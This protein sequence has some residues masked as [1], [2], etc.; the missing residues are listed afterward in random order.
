MNIECPY[1]QAA[2]EL[3]R[4]ITHSIELQACSN[5]LN[6]YAVSVA[7]GNPEASMLP[8]VNDVRMGARPDSLAGQ[9]L[10]C[11]PA[12]L[13]SL[14]VLPAISQ[15]V[16]ELVDDPE[17]SMNDLAELIRED[18]VM[19]T[20]VLTVSN[21]ALFG[22]LSEITELGNACARLGMQTVSGIVQTIANENLYKTKDP[23]AQALMEKLWHHAVATAYLSHEI[24]LLMSLPNAG[25]YHLAGLVHD[26]G[27]IALV[28][29]IYGAKKGPIAELKDKPELLHEIISSYHPLVGLHIIQG[30]NLP[31]E[32][33]VAAF[34]HHDPDD[35][36]D[37]EW[38]TITHT[39]S[40]ANAMAHVSDWESE[41]RQDTALIT[42]P[43]AVYFSLTD[44]KLATMR[45]DLDEKME[46]LL[47]A[48]A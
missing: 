40:L 27:K 45:V 29:T 25:V 17:S 35:V 30:W 20:K 10:A 43:S 32:F 41:Y 14:P 5:C 22:G 37:D 9:L 15:K 48:L 8:G 33:A 12:A 18:T 44:I 4:S 19:S 16:L 31:P 7:S 13:D 24:A 6:P 47:S 38:K 3:E 42:H 2:T 26:I 46:S 21:S 11:I 39:V 28:D 36:P 23:T 34:Y 1:C